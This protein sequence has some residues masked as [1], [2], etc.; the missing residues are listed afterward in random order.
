[1]LTQGSVCNTV[2]I[3]CRKACSRRSWL[4]VNF[5]ISATDL[6]FCV[7]AICVTNVVVD[8]SYFLVHESKGGGPPVV[9]VQAS[10]SSRKIE[11]VIIGIAI[12]HLP[13]VKFVDLITKFLLTTKPNFQSVAQNLSAP[14]ARSC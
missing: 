1:L 10:C 3:D 4:E 2:N 11:I 14:S 8:T 12:N 6:C 9:V 13:E 7:S 5:E